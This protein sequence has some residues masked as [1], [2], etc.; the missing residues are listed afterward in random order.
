MTTVVFQSFRTTDVP[1]WIARCLASVRE[2][3]RSKGWDYRF[4]DDA[5]L[6]MVPDWYLEKAA[7][8]LPIATDLGR[9]ELARRLLAEGYRRTVWLDADVLV[10]DPENFNID[11]NSEFAFGREVWVQRDGGGRLKVFR[12]VHNAVSVFVEGNSFLDFYVH[13]CLSIVGRFEGRMVPQIVGTKF[14]TAL[15]N[16]VGFALID[17]VAM[18]GPV[19]LEDI[20]R[21]G[22]PAIELHRRTLG[23][24]VR[25]ANLCSSLAA[26][27]AGNIHSDAC[28][29]LL[30]TRGGI[31]N[32]SGA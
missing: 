24:P 21:G 10:F 26:G 5:I 20:V 28:D 9:L 23:A 29:A 16:M 15:H 30:E 11:T 27:P 7:G 32:G 19:V 6:D 12:N 8:C 18:F 1:P 2:W 14:L 13:S 3:A 4:V 31:V 25:A 17:A 22:G